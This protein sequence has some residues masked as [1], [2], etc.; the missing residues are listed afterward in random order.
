[1]GFDVVRNFALRLGMTTHRSA[2]PTEDRQSDLKASEVYYMIGG[3]YTI[4]W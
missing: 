4:S 1:L 3:Q 2:W